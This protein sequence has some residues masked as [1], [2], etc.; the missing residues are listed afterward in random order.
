[1]DIIIRSATEADAD[2]C[3]RICYEGFRA[4]TDRHGF[5]PNFES[6]EQANRLIRNF[7]QHPSIYG[8]VA[9]TN[10]G[11]IVGFNFLSERDPIRAVGPIVIDPFVQKR[12]IGQRLM[13]ATLDRA[14]G[15]RG[16]RLLQGAFNMQSLCLYASLGFDAKELLVVLTGTPKSSRPSGWEVRPLLES[17]LEECEALHTRVHGHPRTNELS[18]ALNLSTPIVAFRDGRLRA[19]LAAP[20]NWL[21][22]HAVAEMDEDMMALLLGA[23]QIVKKPL[24]F[25]FPVRDAALFRWCLTENFR[26]TTPMT[27]MTVGEYTEPKG[28]Y[29]SSV[30]Y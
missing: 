30:L 14:Q 9:E 7:I 22:N 20:T 8:I 27:L 18:G 4:I 13:K 16:V 19:Y 15:A 2:A 1:M 24:S 28:R 25:L 17:D 29:F 3:G 21:E 11:R 26:A 23:N 12:G 6:V 5:P 10:D